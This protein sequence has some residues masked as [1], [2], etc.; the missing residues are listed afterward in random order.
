MVVPARES[1]S[2]CVQSERPHHSK[3][4]P[5]MPIQGGKQIGFGPFFMQALIF[6]IP[7][8][9]TRNTLKLSQGSQNIILIY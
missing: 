5:S 4:L 3:S 9:A 2:V 6:K 1:E 8:A 7:K